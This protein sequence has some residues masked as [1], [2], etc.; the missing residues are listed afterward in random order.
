VSDTTPLT[1]SNE[2]NATMTQDLTTETED[3]GG[4]WTNCEHCLESVL[5]DEADDDCLCPK[6]A[7]AAK[8]HAEA[9]EQYLDAVSAFE[10]AESEVTDVENEIAELVGQLA[11]A[12]RELASAKG[13][14]KTADK[15]VTKCGEL[16][17]TAERALEAL[18]S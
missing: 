10:N 6:C 8:T 14:L 4:E 16:L 9:E 17:E 11:E 1:R 5:I 12:R 18:E 15:V 13:R 3:D 2:M 7:A